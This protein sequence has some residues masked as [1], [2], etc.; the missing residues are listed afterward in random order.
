MGSPSSW[1]LSIGNPD[2]W[3][4]REAYMLRVWQIMLLALLV[5]IMFI[6]FRRPQDN[7]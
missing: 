6:M 2:S 3:L 4:N 5:V 1:N 7:Y